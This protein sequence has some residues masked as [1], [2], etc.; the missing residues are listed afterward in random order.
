MTSSTAAFF[1]L[2]QRIQSQ[3]IENWA[4]QNQKHQNR[5]NIFDHDH[6]K[7]LTLKPFRGAFHLIGNRLRL[8]SI[9]NKHTGQKRYDRHQNTVGKE[10]KEIQNAHSLKTDST[11]DTKSQRR[12]NCHQDG[13]NRHKNRDH[14]AAFSKAVS[15]VNS[16]R[17]STSSTALK[18][19][20]LKVFFIILLYLYFL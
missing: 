13:I 11:P 19:G 3:C 15:W 16:M 10:V 8:Y 17:R 1:C 18:Y 5:W 4:D 9:S 20:V 6:V 7:F 2:L 12:R 14:P